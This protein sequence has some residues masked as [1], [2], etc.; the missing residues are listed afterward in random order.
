MKK[1]AS[2]ICP[3]LSQNLSN[4]VAQQSW[5][6]VWLKKLVF[7][8][9]IFLFNLTLPAE[10]RRILKNKKEKKRKSWTDV[11]LKKVKN[12]TDFWLY[13]IYAVEWW[14][15]PGGAYTQP[16]VMSETITR[17]MRKCNFGLISAVCKLGAL[18]SPEGSEKSTILGH[19]LGGSDFLRC[20][21]SLG[22][23]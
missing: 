12:W 3:R 8:C 6:D 9:H 16:E 22:N 21:C 20:D 23:P 5:T 15:G 4:Y 18:Q 19:F 10:R 14:E 13:S 11:W 2:K 17:W 1:V 7:C